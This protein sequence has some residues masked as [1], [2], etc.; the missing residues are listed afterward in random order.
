MASQTHLTKRVGHLLEVIGVD[1]QHNFATRP[2]IP[3][4]LRFPDTWVKRTQVSH[5]PQ[6]FA[7]ELLGI[8]AERVGLED[9]VESADLDSD[10]P[11]GGEVVG[12]TSDAE[13][14]DGSTASA[15]EIVLFLLSEEPSGL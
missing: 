9:F 13:A 15:A 8:E 1:P 3:N 14:A 6:G 11:D 5:E 10:L 7:V 4:L 2:S 12:S